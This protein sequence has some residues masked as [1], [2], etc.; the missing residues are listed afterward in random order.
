MAEDSSGMV[1]VQHLDGDPEQAPDTGESR[2][3]PAHDPSHHEVEHREE[4][5][6]CSG[7]WLTGCKE[8]CSRCAGDVRE[9]PVP[10]P[11]SGEESAGRPGSVGSG[12]VQGPDLGQ[13]DGHPKEK[14]PLVTP[15]K[16]CFLDR[17]RLCA[18]DC[19]SYVPA[20]KGSL[21]CRILI[22]VN[23]LNRKLSRD[24]NRRNIPIPRVGR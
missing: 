1:P 9:G 15:E 3:V 8:G 23:N 17:L 21:T 5:D 24:E 13:V 11:G 10:I 19:T 16:I 6:S 14:V 12:D 22:T 18:E 20:R 2:G 4:Q 7:V